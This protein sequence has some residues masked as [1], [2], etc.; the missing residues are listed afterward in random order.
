MQQE[1]MHYQPQPQP[2]Y[3]GEQPRPSAAYYGYAQKISGPVSNQV[4]SAGQRLALAIVSLSLLVFLILSLV[5]FA[6]A[7][8]TPGWA[9]IPIAFIII[10]FSAVATIINVVFNRRA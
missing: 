1:E 8:H 7:D 9:A 3:E 4:A 6:A 2:A 10:V 5:T